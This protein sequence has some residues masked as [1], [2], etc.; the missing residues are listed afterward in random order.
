MSPTQSTL[1]LQ[2]TFAISWHTSPHAD[3]TEKSAA[4]VPSFTGSAGHKASV[5]GCGARP[6]VVREA[7]R[8]KRAGC[9]AAYSASVAVSFFALK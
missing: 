9:T 4:E 2:V 6:Q 7:P 3:D 5:A 8:N 1:A